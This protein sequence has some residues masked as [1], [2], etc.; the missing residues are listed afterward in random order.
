MENKKLTPVIPAWFDLTKYEPASYLDISGW[1]REITWRMHLRE[2]RSR[3]LP[4][5][6]PFERSPEV[7]TQNDVYF[8]SCFAKHVE[9]PVKLRPLQNSSELDHS[10][11]VRD[12]KVMDVLYHAE[13]L[14]EIEKYADAFEAHKFSMNTTEEWAIKE[15]HE[16]SGSLEEPVNEHLAAQFPGSARYMYVEVDIQTP[17]DRLL[18]SF[19]AWVRA[20]KQHRSQIFAEKRRFGES[21]FAK[22]ARY[23]IL[24][25][26]D[27]KLWSE[28]EGIRIP[29]WLYVD[30]LFRDRQGDTA[31]FFRKTMK[32]EAE[33]V[34]T[35]DCCES[36]QAQA[37][38]NL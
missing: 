5:D 30:V 17:I 36:L 27:L 6:W 19:E 22:W 14:L 1:H 31:T 28:M 10:R 24:P 21:D 13:S 35:W 33:R 23:K 4:A 3:K 37:D 2:L 8:R 25:Y 16:K 26:F 38:L 7:D 18:T 29:E 34:F 32:P 15:A 9:L 11:V 20:A 12:M